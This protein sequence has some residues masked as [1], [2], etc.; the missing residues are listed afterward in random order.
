MDYKKPKKPKRPYWGPLALSLLLACAPQRPVDR[1]AAQLSPRGNFA[2]RAD[3]TDAEL[4]QAG[5]ERL[6]RLCQPDG[7]VGVYVDPELPEG[8]M[9]Y[10]QRM[11]ERLGP[12]GVTVEPV[13]YFIRISPHVHGQL[14]LMVL[15]HEWAHCLAYPSDEVLMDPSSNGGHTREWGLAMWRTFTAVWY[16]ASTPSCPVSSDCEPVQ[17]VPQSTGDAR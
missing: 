7:P 8:L 11:G 3:H 13:G 12:D 4:L 15:C 9:G 5:M 14:L 2:V 6:H 1:G 17:P 16:N 10:T